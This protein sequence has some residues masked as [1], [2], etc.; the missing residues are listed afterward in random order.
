[1]KRTI[2]S[3]LAAALLFSA[4]VLPVGA[5]GEDPAS[6]SVSRSVSAL[7]QTGGFFGN[8]LGRLLKLITFTDESRIRKAAPRDAAGRQSDTA[9][10]TGA[11][12]QTLSAE[13]WRAVEL[14]F[15]SAKTY[16][17]PFADVTLDLLLY[18]SGRLYT[19]PGFW[20]GGNTWRV[21][22]VCPAEG[23]WQCKTVCSDETNAAMHGRTAA[24]ECAAYAG[25]LNVYRHGFVT[26]RYGEKYLTYEDGT[27]F[28]YLGDTHW[29]LAQETPEMIAAICEKR[30]EQGFTVYESQ[31][32]DCGFNT[33]VTENV[34]EEGMEDLRL[35]D[36]KFRIIA[37]SGLIHANSQFFWPLS[38][39]TRLIN[40]HG[41]WTE[42]KLTGYL[43]TK[44]VTMPDLSD[45]AKAY[46]E[47][48]SRYWVARFSAF[49]V[50]W[51]LG[52]EIDNDPY[53]N[54]E[55]PWNAVNNPYKYVAEYL[56]KYDPY[57][58][59][60]TAHQES[61]GDTAAYGNGLGTGEI[62]MIWYP[63]AQPSAFRDV[64]AHTMYAA[65][66]H[67]NLT[68]RDDYMSAR[69]YWYNGQGK[70]VVNYEGLYCYLWTKNYG[71]RAQAWASYL[72]GL[73]GCSWG[74]Q[75]TWAYQ[76]GFERDIDSDDGIDIIRAEEKQ[77]ATWQ[78]ALEYPS[79]YQMGYMRSFMEQLEWYDLIPRFNNWAYFVPASNVYAYCASNKANTEMVVY[80]YSFTD[81]TV[82][83]RINTEK[84]GGILT[85]TVGSLVPFAEYTYKWF[86]PITG[87][88]TA[89]G[90]FK[91]SS[92][93]TWF[94]G[95]RP[96]DTDYV[97]LI[98]KTK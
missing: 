94:A 45:E 62:N 47:K 43:G 91:A 41:G 18:G 88:Y 89:E 57:A 56:A 77:A 86:D 44:R 59:P 67:P 74:G 6:V 19:V 84:N 27:P 9:L 72:T 32:M 69:D 17:D 76:N 10:F 11:A 97:L 50:I 80:F 42:P 55:S 23:T 70:P 96:A 34:G 2:A 73:Y 54:E 5:S 60:V 46:L 8:L 28:Y 4:A 61:T 65:Q 95:T 52:Q 78:D 30:V 82:G 71:A 24:V 36:E 26:T 68:R 1:M 7:E 40:N 81:P 98:R 53:Q 85:G 87:E 29:Q 39:M 48:I 58:H 3:I 12:E 93:G 22:F 20:D 66:W 31:P 83:E 51:T 33:A 16:G 49:P 63:G 13:T 75:P 64:A 25:D 92:L 90:T 79:T 15:E 38:G 35:F 37:D 21:R 14:T